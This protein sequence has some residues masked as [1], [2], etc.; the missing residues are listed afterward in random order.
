MK[1]LYTFI[2]ILSVVQMQTIAQT[3]GIKGQVKGEGIPVPGT[4]P[5]WNK[6]VNFDR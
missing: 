4:T 2:T 1:I 3:G 6:P 5:E